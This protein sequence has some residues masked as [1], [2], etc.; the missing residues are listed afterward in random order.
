MPTQHDLVSFVSYIIF[1]SVYKTSS[2]L[3]VQ[4]NSPYISV[5]NTQLLVVGIRWHSSPVF[6]FVFVFIALKGRGRIWTSV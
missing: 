6:L 5:K 2:Y 3:S 1:S 4:L